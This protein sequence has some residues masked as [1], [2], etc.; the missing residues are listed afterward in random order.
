ME[1][2]FFNLS[3]MEQYYVSFRV[4]P[5]ED[6]AWPLAVLPRGQFEPLELYSHFAFSGS[7]GFGLL[8]L[9]YVLAGSMRDEYR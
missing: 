9:F 7:C 8:Y 3:L 5:Q 4:F 2:L 6:C 1:V